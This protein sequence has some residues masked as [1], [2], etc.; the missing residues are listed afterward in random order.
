M[1]MNSGYRPPTEWT[2][3]SRPASP[4]DGPPARLTMK[5]VAAA[6]DVSLKTVS[7]VVNDESGVRPEV[8]DRVIEAINRLGFRRN[9]V[10]R[11]LRAGHGIS[12]IALIVADLTN[13]FYSAVAKAVEQV[14]NR[15]NAV[16][17]IA[18]S[19]ED[20][21]RERELAT[22]LVHRPVDGLLI[23]PVGADHKYLETEMRMG[24]QMVFFDRPAGN[25]E[26]DAVVLDNIGGTRQ[27]ILHLI[28]RGHK[29]I[30]FIGDRTS[31]ATASER[32][33]GYRMALADAGLPMDPD[34]VVM[35][36]HAADEAEIAAAQILGLRHPPTAMFAAN[37]RICIGALRA[38]RESGRLVAIIGFDDF[39]LADLLPIPVTVVAYDAGEIGRA[40]G[41]LLFSRLG[42]DSRPPQKIVIPTRLVVRGSGELKP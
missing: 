19:G 11:S 16:V 32:L 25:I 14:A 1:V 30:G 24:V 8:R 41:E 4:A 39:E 10:A 31:I 12:S 40:A 23:V 20:A 27:A 7:R 28:R 37:N 36:A 6:A 29:R 42:G 17:V 18:S 38:I 35:G 15:H 22:E 33:E 2:R 5:D 34:L 3:G 21:A 9:V 13:P 26:A